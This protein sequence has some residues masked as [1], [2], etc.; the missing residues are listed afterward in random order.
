MKKMSKVKITDDSQIMEGKL[1]LD[2]AK[3]FYSEILYCIV[4]D[5][6]SIDDI[7]DI[8]NGKAI[9]PEKLLASFKLHTEV[10]IDDLI[11]DGVLI[12]VQK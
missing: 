9:M 1:E 2:K 11:H 5:Y 3:Q 6:R 10:F 4:N 7:N 8:V 12:R